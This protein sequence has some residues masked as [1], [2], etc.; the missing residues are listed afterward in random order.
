MFTEYA[1]ISDIL[2]IVIGTLSY[3]LCSPELPEI[4]NFLEP[5]EAMLEMISEQTEKLVH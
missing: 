1:D 5:L 3:R 4:P 2:R